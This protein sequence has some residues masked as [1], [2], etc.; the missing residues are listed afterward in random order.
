M[1]AIEGVVQ[2]EAYQIYLQKIR[3]GR[4]GNDKQDWFEACKKIGL[5]NKED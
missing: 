3:E 5:I 4:P 2:R 1:N